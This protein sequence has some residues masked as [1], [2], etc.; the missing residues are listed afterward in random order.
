MGGSIRDLVLLRLE[1]A[2][3]ML[4]A[5]Q[6]NYDQGELKTS[7]NRSYYAIFHAMR[8]VNLL[9]GFDSS[10][11]SGVIAHFNQC[12]LKTR[13][14]SPAFSDTIKRA[15]Y[16]REKSDYD[17]FYVVSQDEVEEQLNNAKEFVNKVKQYLESK[18]N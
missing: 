11:H 3:E 4:S 17:D 1:R 14:I 9:D 13:E 16:C 15:S 10:K 12:Y 2:E 7:L 6:I 18:I 8:S 5:S